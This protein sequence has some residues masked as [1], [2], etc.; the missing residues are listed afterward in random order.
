M[1]F[2]AKKGIA[3][4]LALAMLAVMLSSC[5]GSGDTDGGDETTTPANGETTTIPNGG[6]TTAPANGETITIPNGGETTAPVGGEE[7][8]TG[9]E[10]APKPSQ[11]LVFT[12][13]GDGTCFV[14]GI[15]TCTDT[16]LVIPSISPDGDTVTGIRF[17]AFPGKVQLKSVVIPDGVTLID[18]EAFYNCVYLKEITIPNSVTD[19]G[20][21]AFYN[22]AYYND[23]ANW[24]C[25]VLYVGN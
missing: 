12:S 8:N 14:S 11:G 15:G 22:T 16:E 24:T 10:E 18:Y 17:L 21:L 2:T 13:N 1:N 25:G 19:I 6:E 23:E 9:G 3:W 20:H 7:E 4:L 5:N